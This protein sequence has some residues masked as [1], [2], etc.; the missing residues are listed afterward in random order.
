MFVLPP[1]ASEFA[2]HWNVSVVLHVLRKD[3]EGAVR[4]LPPKTS[5]RKECWVGGY[6]K[7]PLI[8]LAAYS[9]DVTCPT[10]HVPPPRG[11]NNFLGS[12]T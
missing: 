11:D 7:S 5:Y 8:P 10:F 3:F 1:S 6:A 9:C 4:R 12:N 2:V